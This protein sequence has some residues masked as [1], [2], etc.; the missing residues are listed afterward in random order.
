MTEKKW[1]DNRQPLQICGFLNPPW[2]WK[3]RWNN[4]R[5]ECAISRQRSAV[6]WD[7]L[8]LGKLMPY[9]SG[10]SGYALKR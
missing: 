7:E 2:R 10:A 9:T 6:E 5:D 4:Q 8:L 1:T 3:Y